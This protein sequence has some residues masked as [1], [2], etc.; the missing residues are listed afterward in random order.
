MIS[1]VVFGAVCVVSL[2]IEIS[3]VSSGVP[4]TN[5]F[6]DTSFTR[7]FWPILG[8]SLGLIASLALGVFTLRMMRTV[9]GRTAG[10][11]GAA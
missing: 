3:W 1:A 6:G 11:G 7:Y 8:V 4:F 9:R 5:Y 10:P 2:A